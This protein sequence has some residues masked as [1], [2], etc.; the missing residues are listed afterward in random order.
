MNEKYSNL[1]SK[2]WIVHS[3]KFGNSPNIF[4]NA[5]QPERKFN[6]KIRITDEKLLD[7]LACKL[8]IKRT[9]LL[10]Y[11]L[12]EGLKKELKKMPVQQ[13]AKILIAT[14]ADTK[15]A[16]ANPFKEN[17]WIKQLLHEEINNF[18][19]MSIDQEMSPIYPGTGDRIPNSESF[20][21]LND[22]FKRQDKK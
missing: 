19:V 11:L 13:D 3:E 4:I 16:R 5:S 2:R 1:T 8:N 15:L 7:A 22:F 9:T 18:I 21:T 17:F 6:L 20:T 14:R 10:N 12:L